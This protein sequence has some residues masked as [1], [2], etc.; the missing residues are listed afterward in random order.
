MTESQR[1]VTFH[2]IVAVLDRYQDQAKDDFLKWDSAVTPDDP[3]PKLF[4]T[5]AI[6]SQRKACVA[7]EV[8]G[9]LIERL[10]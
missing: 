5:T 3:N 7:A 8:L 10:R 9:S 1:I 4:R 6:E 2:D